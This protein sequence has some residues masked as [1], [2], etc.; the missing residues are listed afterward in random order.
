MG[1]LESIRLIDHLRDPAMRAI[2]LPGLI[3]GLSTVVVCALL[4]PLVVVRR[5]GFVGQGISHCAFGGVGVAAVLAAYG[6]LGRGSVME[7]AVVSVFCIS[8]ALGMGMIADRRQT[9]EDSTIGMFL[10]GSMAVGAL[11]VTMAR[12]HAAAAGRMP[13]TRSWESIL[14]GS[15]MVAG[16][17]EMVLSIGVMVVVTAAVWLLRRAL[18]FW[19]FDEDSAR[20][21]GVP[22]GAMRAALMILLAL[23]VVTAMRTAGVVL[24]SALLVLPGATALRLSD[25]LGTVVGISIACGVIG[26]LV[27]MAMS[28]QLDWQPGPSIVLVMV[29]MFV[30]ALAWSRASRRV[31][32][33]PAAE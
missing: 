22:A 4:S 21:F 30:A 10:V 3:A 15:V 9:P 14:F 7:F 12:D 6:L 11:L 29:A 26:L 19:A 27:G 18:L 8:A 28:I 32:A 20:A 31:A 23:V 17:V 1:A 2:Y 33:T 13:D 5:L 16:D 25:R 24:A